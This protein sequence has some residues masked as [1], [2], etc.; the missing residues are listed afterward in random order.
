VVVL[1]LAVLALLGNTL[2]MLPRHFSAIYSVAAT[3]TLAGGATFFLHSLTFLFE[4]RPDA[5]KPAPNN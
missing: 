4:R 3:M 1:D 2:P 5:A